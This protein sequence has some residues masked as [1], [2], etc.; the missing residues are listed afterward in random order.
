MNA[1][2]DTFDSPLK[3]L[4]AAVGAFLVLAALGT[5]IGA[6]WATAQTLLVAIV[7]IVGALLM[8]GIGAGILYVS[9]AVEE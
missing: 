4:G 7:Q 2:Q 5:I 9:F 3:P 6:P 1:L 8:A